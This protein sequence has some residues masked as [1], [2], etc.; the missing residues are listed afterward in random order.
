MIDNNSIE[1]KDGS[2]ISYRTT[3]DTS[4]TPIFLL[5][6]S[7][8]N[9]KQYDPVLIP[10][11]KKQIKESYYIINYDYV[12]FGASSPIMGD[13]NFLEITRQH[14]EL[15]DA[16]GIEQAHHFGYSKGSLIS[17]FTSSGNPER[18]TSV[19]GYGNPNLAL[20]EETTR[21]AFSKRLQYI[22]G[23]SGIWHELISKKN[24]KIVYDTVFLP[25]IFPN[26]TVSNLSFKEKFMNWWIRNKIQPMLEGTLIE[27]IVKLY[28][29]YIEETKPEEKERY[30]EAMKKIKT[31]TLLLHGTF[32][33]TVPINGSKLLSEWIESSV[34][35]EF[36]FSH[37]SPILTRKQGSKIMKEYVKFLKNS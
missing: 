15:M 37:T 35:I 1:I 12:G 36:P 3:G 20:P 10:A 24:Y 30:I 19:A 34:F 6:G 13:F 21:K 28:Q 18:V 4:K 11:L 26:K 32:D 16:L 17:F 31:P 29:Y 33:E 5:N 23:I 2:K 27:N 14:I 25:T 8:F 22:Q 9:Y 7:V